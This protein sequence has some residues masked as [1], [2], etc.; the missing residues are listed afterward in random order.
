MPLRLPDRL[1]AIELLKQENIFVVD[2][3]RA[4]HQDIRPLR[5]AVLNLMPLKITTETDLVRILSNSPLQLEIHLMKVK[6]HTPKNTP[7]EHMRA[8]YRD[9]EVMRNEKFDGMII[10]GAPVEH[11]EFEQV[12]YWDEISE[13][14]QWSRTHVQSTMYI[15]WAAQAGLYYHYGVQKHP[16]SS[17]MFGI[18]PQKPLDMGL[19]IFR[20]FDDKFNMP[21]SRHTE[22]RRSDIDAVPGLQVIAESPLSGVS[23]VMAR[24]G[25]EI[26]VTGHSEYSPLTLDSEYRRD[27]AKGLPIHMPYNYYI[28]DDMDK[29]VK[30]TWRA[31]GNL[32]FQNW[33]NYYV[34]QETPFDIEDIH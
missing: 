2:E 18:F 12:N 16:L 29:G 9:F 5:I 26:F 25:R 24:D 8:F 15:C 33:L 22:I 6:A 14:F 17:K 31:H 4:S 28:D 27:L 21:H 1:P 7:V 30:V 20:G 11:L 34:Y 13:I 23:M 3:A 19:P 32:L 10:T